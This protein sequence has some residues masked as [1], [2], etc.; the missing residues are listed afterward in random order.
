MYVVC[1]DYRGLDTGKDV[2]TSPTIFYW[3]SVVSDTGTTRFR[4][5]PPFDLDEPFFNQTGRI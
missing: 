5:T 4:Y 2:W 1:V 3:K